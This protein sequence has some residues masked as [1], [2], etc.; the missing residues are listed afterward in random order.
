MQLAAYR[1]GLE[2]PHAR[3]A[4]VFVSRTHPG[5]IKIVEW[6]EDELVKG[7]EMFQALLRFWKL[8]N[9]FGV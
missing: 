6:P 5:L 4:N 9:N 1:H 8:K 3:C 2:V 7:W